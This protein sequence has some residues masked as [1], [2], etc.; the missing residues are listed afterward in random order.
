MET[1]A[2]DDDVRLVMNIQVVADNVADAAARNEKLEEDIDVVRDCI[3]TVPTAV[4]C[5][6]T[7]GRSSVDDGVLEPVAV[8]GAVAAAAGDAWTGTADS[9]VLWLVVTV[10]VV[11]AELVLLQLAA[12][13]ID[14][15]TWVVF[16]EM[17]ATCVALV[18]SPTGAS[19]TVAH[20]GRYIS[21]CLLVQRSVPLRSLRYFF[22]VALFPQRQRRH[23]QTTSV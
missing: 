6:W 19:W 5:C 7:T 17:S 21:P 16:S 23:F 10:V 3:P 20:S 18:T 14:A 4:D 9:A 2:S 8:E 13:L 1:D 22:H 12:V 15:A 11:C